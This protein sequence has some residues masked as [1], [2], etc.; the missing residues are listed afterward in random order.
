MAAAEVKEQK[1]GAVREHR[2]AAHR[3]AVW[4][5]EGLATPVRAAFPQ[6]AATAFGAEAAA[7]DRRARMAATVC[8][9]APA[10]ETRAAFPYLVATAALMASAA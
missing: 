4:C 10:V 8:L 1:G 2:T 5:L 9:A 3:L 7:A 6:T